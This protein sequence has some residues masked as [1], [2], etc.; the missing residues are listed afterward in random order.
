MICTQLS[1]NQGTC[2]SMGKYWKKISV[3]DTEKTLSVHPFNLV[4]HKCQMV[5]LT[6]KQDKTVKNT[7]GLLCTRLS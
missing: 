7:M 1:N 5:K 3:P 4:K 2:I 6:N